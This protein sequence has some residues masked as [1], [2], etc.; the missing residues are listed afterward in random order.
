M[1]DVKAAVRFLRANA[2]KYNIDAKQIGDG[3][4]ESVQVGPRQA[5]IEKRRRYRIA[6]ASSVEYR[7]ECQCSD[8]PSVV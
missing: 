3:L 2:M 6:A 1:Q 4:D 7:A 8:E 5:S